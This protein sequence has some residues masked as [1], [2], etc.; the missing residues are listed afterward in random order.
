MIK[1][2]LKV[3]KKSNKRQKLYARCPECKWEGD[4]IFTE[5][6]Y[7]VRNLTFLGKCPNC[8]FLV[9]SGIN[10][11]IEKLKDWF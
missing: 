10:A 3:L 11:R 5:V 7:K 4:Y 1:N 2:L 8:E 6:I 9:S